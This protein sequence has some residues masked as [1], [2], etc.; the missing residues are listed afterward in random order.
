VPTI[1]VRLNDKEFEAICQYAE[2]CG[3]TI[4]DLA[5]KSLIREATLADGFGADDPS[6]NYNMTV[7][8]RKPSA[9]QEQRLVEQNYN[10]IRRILGWHEIKL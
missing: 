8:V 1:V 9:R 6:Y 10:R 5:R 4:P 7:P 2:Q 3:E